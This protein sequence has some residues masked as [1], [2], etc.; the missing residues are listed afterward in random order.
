MK[1]RLIALIFPV[2]ALI[3]ELLPSGAVLIFKTPHESLRRTFSYF[4]LT[5]TDTLTSVRL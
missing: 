3:L 2:I 5:P 1:K 4:S